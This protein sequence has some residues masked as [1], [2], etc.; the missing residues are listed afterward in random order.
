MCDEKTFAIPPNSNTPH[1]L[2]ILASYETELVNFIF[3]IAFNPMNILNKGIQ[4]LKAKC[5]LFCSMTES[6]IAPFADCKHGANLIKTGISI[7]I[8]YD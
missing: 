2:E 4:A 1:Q 7:H 5:E 6:V 8:K 3:G